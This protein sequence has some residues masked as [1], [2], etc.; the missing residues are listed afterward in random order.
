LLAAIS[1]PEMV[2]L[3]AQVDV[4]YLSYFFGYR[5]RHYLVANSHYFAITE[6]NHSL[7]YMKL[8]E[9]NSLSL[10]YLSHAAVSAFKAVPSQASLKPFGDDVKQE[11]DREYQ[12]QNFAH[13]N[14][15]K[16]RAN[17]DERRNEHEYGRKLLA[18][19][20]SL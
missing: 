11:N 3:E 15:E 13:R 4:V 9:L 18:L 19:L 12:R 16:A 2:D 10:I 5:F 14:S 7:K 17:A 6:G 20:Q 8:N 1:A